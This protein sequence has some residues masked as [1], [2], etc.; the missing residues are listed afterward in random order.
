MRSGIGVFIPV[1][2]LKRHNTP[3]LEKLSWSL[4]SVLES[5]WYILGPRVREFES[6][7]AQYCGAQHC[8]G[9]G[10]GTDALEIA[11]RACG[12]APGDQVATVANA[13][14]YSTAAIRA[15]GALPLYADVAP[16]SMLVELD[17][18]ER[19]LKGAAKTI[20]VT[21][22]YGRMVNMPRV[23]QLASSLDIPVIEDCAQA[24]GAHFE[25]RRAGTWGAL[26]CFSF[27]PTKNLGALGDAGAIVTNDEAL[28]GRV[29]ELH[30]Y[31]WNAKY[32]SRSA[33]GR[34]SRLDEMQAAILLAKLPHLDRWNA[35][36][37]SVAEAYTRAIDGCGVQAPNCSGPDYVAH[38]YVVRVSQRATF[39]RRLELQNVASD[40]H[41]PVPDHW[42]ESAGGQ[43][44]TGSLVET[45]RCCGEVV[46]L[47]CF[48]ELT[49]EEVDRVIAAVRQ[50][51]R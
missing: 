25:G 47:P 48:P 44:S 26:G 29:R 23:M 6:A 36:R 39:R 30:Q 5:G 9:T 18:L 1:N 14:G 49:D 10:N 22:L 33:G 41:Y 28:A 42:Q 3:I 13:G 27:Y 15:L 7:F 4:T 31:G 45:E 32:R 21:H 50:A 34:N 38:L 51:V 19:K 24:H 2:D 40:V 46:T 16:D 8:I 43:S 37:R 12:V 20:I 35:R 11:L 17:D